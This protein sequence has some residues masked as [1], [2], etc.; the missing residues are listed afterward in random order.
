MGTVSSCGEQACHEA[1]SLKQ[2]FGSHLGNQVQKICRHGRLRGITSIAYSFF[3]RHLKFGMRE[4]APGS[5]FGGAYT[6]SSGELALWISINF[7]N[8]LVS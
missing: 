5:V 6:Y 2:P 7:S 1:G 3:Y 8:P 4:E